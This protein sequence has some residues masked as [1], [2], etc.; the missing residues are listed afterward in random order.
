MPVV[1]KAQG[2]PDKEAFVF[3]AL[4]SEILASTIYSRILSD[5]V[6]MESFSTERKVEGFWNR[7]DDKRQA[8]WGDTIE[9]ETEAHNQFFSHFAPDFY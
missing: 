1:K 9:L 4:Q 3:R 5:S 6:L 7:N 2:I 8:L